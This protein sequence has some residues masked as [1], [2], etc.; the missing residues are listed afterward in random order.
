V[1][2]VTQF[3]QELKKIHNSSYSFSVH[4][5]GFRYNRTTDDF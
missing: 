5:R 2:I 1:A 4:H 3:A